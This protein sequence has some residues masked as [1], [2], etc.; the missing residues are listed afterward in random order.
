MTDQQESQEQPGEWTI[1]KIEQVLMVLCI[2]FSNQNRPI[3]VDA[4]YARARR[5]CGA[6]RIL[7]EQAIDNLIATKKIIPGKVLHVKNVLDN[8]TRNA[9][10]N[11]LTR[12]P[13]VLAQDLKNSLDIGTKILLWHLKHLLDFGLI[14]EV[15]WGKTCLYSANS[16]SD[17]DAIC[18]HLIAKNATIQVLLRSIDGTI[19]PQSMLLEIV[20]AKRTTLLYH[21][22]KLTETGILEMIVDEADKKYQISAQYKPHI[23]NI[24]DKYF[25]DKINL[26]I[27]QDV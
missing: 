18:Y 20:P 22:N 4:L 1:E 24:L 27:S 17:K 7:I 19:L 12:V 14:K 13:G 15:K 8:Q 25:S 10:Y 5:D 9:I 11:Y 26:S 21:L 6:P 23:Y 2:E 3:Q 16:T